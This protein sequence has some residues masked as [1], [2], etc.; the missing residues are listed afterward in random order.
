LADH[1]RPARSEL[2]LELAEHVRRTADPPPTSQ[3]PPREP[4]LPSKPAPASIVEIP[5]PTSSAPGNLVRR[6]DGRLFEGPATQRI[7][8]MVKSGELS[9]HDEVSL[10]GAAFQHVDE[11]ETLAPH[12]PPDPEAT[13]RFPGPGVA[14]YADLLSQTSVLQL[15][16]WILQMQETGA[17]FL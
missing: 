5:S 13:R 7:V 4:K 8:E 1:E 11:I 3:K 14:D 2:R 9:R 17:V 6:R 12:L 16:A 10:A 15:L